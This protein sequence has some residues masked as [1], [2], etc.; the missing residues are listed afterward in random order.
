MDYGH[1]ED[2]IGDAV[3]WC[4]SEFSEER[5]K[6]YR[7][8]H[9][10]CDVPAEAGR[11]SIVVQKLRDAVRMVE[12]AVLRPFLTV[13][14]PVEFLG[15]T[16]EDDAI[17]AQMTDACKYEIFTANPGKQIMR[18]IV[19]DNAFAQFAV[20]KSW[21]EPKEVVRSVKFSGLS[22]EEVA[23]LSDEREITELEEFNGLFSGSF[24]HTEDKGRH[25][26]RGVPPEE[27]FIDSEAR[28]VEDDYRVLGNRRQV[29]VQ[30]AI[31]LGI[32]E[33][34]VLEHVST[35][36]R[37]EDE[38]LE[39][40]NRDTDQ[41]NEYSDPMTQ[42]VVL[43]EA[44]VRLADAGKIRLYRVYALGSEHAVVDVEPVDDHP[45]S[46][47]RLIPTQHSFHGESLGE[48]LFPDQDAATVLYRQLLDNTY[49]VNQPRTL[50][51]DS[52]VNMNDALSTELGAVVR[53]RGNVNDSW[54]EIAPPYTGDKALQ[55]LSFVDEH[56][57]RKSG[58]SRAGMGLDPDVMQSTTKSAVDHQIRAATGNSEM[59]VSS[60]ADG[61]CRW[62]RVVA[63]ILHHHASQEYFVKLRGEYVPI[64]PAQWDLDMDMEANVG[65]GTGQPEQKVSVLEAVVGLQEQWKAQLG[66]GNPIVT[67]KN[68]INA[69]EDICI[70]SGVT[71][72]SRYFSFHEGVDQEIAQVIQQREQAAQ[73]QQQS[74]NSDAAYVRG[75]E[76]EGQTSLQ[77]AQIEQQTRLKTEEMKD[78]RERGRQHIDARI[79]T[80]TEAARDDRERDKM[81]QDLELEAARIA[82]QHQV[83]VD[84]NA[85][86]REQDK[87]RTGP[88]GS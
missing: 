70:A 62:M 22:Y 43:T 39:R 49:L 12:P 15:R 6:A 63:R 86:V 65:L 50:M 66:F 13:R 2:L 76:I 37:T 81:A 34:V 80:T 29:L 25:V 79:R 77:R 36:D 20:V 72:P 84:K 60:L 26:S 3:D 46:V 21:W 5:K 64:N 45:F 82:G 11:S 58:V 69:I 85:I 18:D 71:N 35:E 8:Y 47:F 16:R 24:E 78:D 14:R 52:M 4:E 19:R 28:D 59:M 30:D 9:G 7:Y 1:I 55:V 44:Y 51:N 54:R 42:P 48:I 61:M 31:N 53:C 40:Q 41:D 73:E 74:G 32:S 38:E 27:F 88:L 57:D 68:Q 56:A 33:D 87:P 10:E 75:K 23:V 67:V 83:A 17:A